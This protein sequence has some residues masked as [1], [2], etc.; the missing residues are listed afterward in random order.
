LSNWTIKK[1]EQD[2]H[3]GFGVTRLLGNISKKNI[4]V[5]ARYSGSKMAKTTFFYKSIQDSL[6]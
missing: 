3:H 5:N 4:R 2:D 1:E 6:K